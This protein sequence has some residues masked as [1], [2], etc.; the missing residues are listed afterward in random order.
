MENEPRQDGNYEQYGEVFHIDYGNESFVFTPKNTMLCTYDNSL[1][2]H[3]LHPR[4]G[5]RQPIALSRW[6]C[7]NLWKDMEAT[8]MFVEAHREQPE[9]YV[10]ASPDIP[11]VGI[12]GQLVV[13]AMEDMLS[14]L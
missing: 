1:F 14:E 13:R 4:P 5:D 10:L 9:E 7:G 3:I 6:W 2:D 12:I 8:E 11:D